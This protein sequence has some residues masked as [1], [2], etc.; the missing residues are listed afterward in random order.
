MVEPG[1]IQRA[2][3]KDPDARREVVAAVGDRLA[4]LLDRMGLPGEAADDIVQETWLVVLDGKS[5]PD[6]T[7]QAGVVGWIVGIARNKALRWRKERSKDR[8]R[9]EEERVA[10]KKRPR[11][12]SAFTAAAADDTDA[13]DEPGYE[14]LYEDAIV[15][16]EV[17]EDG[18]A[19]EPMDRRVERPPQVAEPSPVEPPH[20][21]AEPAIDAA[22]G[23]RDTPVATTSEART[24]WLVPR[25]F[26]AVFEQ[27]PACVVR[28]WD[29][30]TQAPEM[31]A[32]TL[33]SFDII[34]LGP[35]H[36]S[37]VVDRS[38]LERLG[39]VWWALAEVARRRAVLM[40]LLP[41]RDETTRLSGYDG[42]TPWEL[43]VLT[44]ELLDL[45]GWRFNSCAKVCDETIIATPIAQGWHEHIIRRDDT[46]DASGLGAA[47]I[48]YE[49]G[50]VMAGWYRW[51]RA[52]VAVLPFDCTRELHVSDVSFVRDVAAEVLGGTDVVPLVADLRLGPKGRG[53]GFVYDANDTARD[54]PLP[55]LET[56]FVLAFLR[57]L[58][59]GGV[60]RV[61]D[62][63][64]E[65]ELT[66]HDY[67]VTKVSSV[68][69]HVN[70]KLAEAFEAWGY[71]PYDVF[72]AGNG[73]TTLTYP[74]Q[75][76]FTRV[77][78]LEPS[79]P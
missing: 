37:G 39:T 4:T 66:A 67:T 47:W 6:R 22:V 64:I 34:V 70:T 69:S 33:G 14:I 5:L 19:D 76:Q 79:P 17:V 28:T 43:R 56:A 18:S 38:P 46:I 68:R 9:D 23:P 13:D 11:H 3:E 63:I 29:E 35:V 12:R 1:L 26:G 65:A 71:L 48:G 41:G 50:G 53:G 62:H 36:L 59:E 72:T 52:K 44:R 24:L 10:M 55:R 49:Y 32:R 21:A 20:R 2:R 58:H 25:A 57:G 31:I 61:P 16:E 60:P 73:S 30:V 27:G 40:V 7:D 54:Y 45:A 42:S 77:L 8:D 75:D 51:G 78:G 15:E 74:S